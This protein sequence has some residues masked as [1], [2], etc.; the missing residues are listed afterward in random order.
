[1]AELA[2]ALALGASGRKA[3]Q[4]RPLFLAPNKMNPR[5]RECSGVSCLHVFT[6]YAVACSSACR[7][8]QHPARQ[9]S[10]PSLALFAS[11]RCFMRVAVAFALLSC[12][13]SLWVGRSS[14]SFNWS[15]QRVK[16]TWGR[17]RLCWMVCQSR[18]TPSFCNSNILRTIPG[19]VDGNCSSGP[20]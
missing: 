19:S 11:S 15:R 1:M 18:T 16:R 10:K 5:A 20:V 6:H 8:G 17:L 2:D 12:S 13:F 9:F 3:V 14:S 7:V 4:V